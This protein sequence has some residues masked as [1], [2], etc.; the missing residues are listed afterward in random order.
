MSL[1]IN[2]WKVR[3]RASAGPATPQSELISMWYILRSDAAT[4]VRNR[5][6]GRRYYFGETTSTT[7]KVTSL[8]GNPIS[9]EDLRPD[10]SF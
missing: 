4:P 8:T 9:K 5:G 2:S 3:A 1:K 10:I 6:T 7:S